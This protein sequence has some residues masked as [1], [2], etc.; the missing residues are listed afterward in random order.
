M[1]LLERRQRTTVE[2]SID[3][4]HDR[5]SG[6]L[7]SGYRLAM[8]AAHDDVA[9]LRVVYV[10]TK[11]APDE[12]TE[13]VVRL[14]HARPELPSLADLSF[15]ASRF[16][17]EMLDLFGIVPLDHPQPRRLVLHQHWPREWYPMRHD[18]GPMP[19]MIADAASYPFIPVDGPG[20]FEIPV[21][22][23]G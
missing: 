9:S 2:T 23:P 7:G 5:V 20:I 3:A 19:A 18:A 17:R 13:L 8:V 10:F 21:G 22:P 11:G 12:C 15:V 1:T 6:L 14:E 16:E 4:L